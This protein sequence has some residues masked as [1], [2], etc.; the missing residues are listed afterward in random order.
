MKKGKSKEMGCG[1]YEDSPN[2]KKLKANGIAGK[3]S[4]INASRDQSRTSMSKSKKG[5]Y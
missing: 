2:F 4:G 1:M 5:S 3:A